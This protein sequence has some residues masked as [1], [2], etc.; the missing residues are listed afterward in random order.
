MDAASS[1]YADETLVN[2]NGGTDKGGPFTGTTP[3]EVAGFLDGLRNKMGGTNIHF[4]V[5][6]VKG[7]T[8]KDT[9][10]SDAGTGTCF[11]TWAKDGDGNWKIIKGNTHKDTWTSDA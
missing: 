3:D 10:T 1:G 8:H 6:E 2:V 4:I 7:N 11:A 5:T 9:W